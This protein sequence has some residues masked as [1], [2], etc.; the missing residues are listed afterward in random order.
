MEFE[1]DKEM[2]AIL[3]RARAGEA[4]ASFDSHPDAD[5]IAAFAENA[6]SEAARRRYTAHFA[7]C[8]RCRKILSNIIVFTAEAETIETASSIVPAEIAEIAAAK[9]PWYR[10]LFV[11]PQIAYTMGAFVLLFSGFFGYII[12]R[13]L[14][15]AGNSDVSYSTDKTSPLEKSAPQAAPAN[16]ASANKP[17]ANLPAAPANS[18]SAAN[19]VPPNA[20]SNTAVF[21]TPSESRSAEPAPV[22][23]STPP[24]QPAAAPPIVTETLPTDGVSERDDKPLAKARP[25]SEVNKPL[26]N[27]GA[28]RDENKR[29]QEN[30][31][32]LDGQS[33]TDSSA[34]RKL[35]ST[36]SAPAVPKK[37]DR[38]DAKPGESRSVGG[39]TFNNVGGTWFDSAYSNQKRKTVQRG[40]SEYQKL[41]AGLRSIADSLG[42][43]VVVLWKGK[44]YQIQ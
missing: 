27:G 33:T 14:P 32:L 35:K 5:E 17:A 42:G 15:G 29:E 39:K 13:N 2:D 23:M 9:I 8:A 37:Q 43:T 7:D 12:L 22:P 6:V 36:R 26:V 1:F 41:D 3:R 44:A 34:D 38:P 25:E 18:A 28:V 4:V 19:S 31:F 21:A 10:K 16:S 30:S 24:N 11:F 40:T 20:S